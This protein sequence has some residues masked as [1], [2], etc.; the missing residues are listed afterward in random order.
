MATRTKTTKSTK[1]AKVVVDDIEKTTETPVAQT[2]ENEQKEV[3]TNNTPVIC[4]NGTRGNL[5][6]KST[7]NLGYEV[8]W[9]EFG[10]EQQ[11]EFGELLVMRGSQ[12]RFFEDNW[13]IIDDPEVVKK[14]GVGKYYKNVPSVEDFD[15]IFDLPAD[16]LK[17]TISQMS[18]GMKDSVRIRAR[19]LLQDGV[20]DSR[21][22]I[23]AIQEAT[24]F[25]IVE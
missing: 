2:R 20:I 15:D 5:I 18:D 22:T 17:E 16:E 24:G 1:A 11:I 6:Y 23:N 14:L 13:I 9:S 25:D 4:R 3:I 19:E 12:R 7:R 10:E 21:S 8:E